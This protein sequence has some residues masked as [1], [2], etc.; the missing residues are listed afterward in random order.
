[1]GWLKLQDHG[2][3]IKLGL[4]EDNLH[5]IEPGFYLSRSGARGVIYHGEAGW[6]PVVGG[7]RLPG[8]YR[9]GAWRTSA[10]GEDV[11]LGV[12]GL[13]RSNLSVPALRR[14]APYGFYV[15]GQQHLTGSATEDAIT[16]RIT[17]RSGLDAFFNYVRTDPRTTRIIDQINV[18]LYFNGPLAS[19]PNDY[20]GIGAARTR[21]NP[22]AAAAEAAS[23]VRSSRRGAEIEIEAHY[24]MHA[25]QGLTLKPS[26]QYIVSPGGRRTAA[27]AVVL[28]FRV[29]ADF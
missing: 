1:M 26:I 25:A 16:G 4:Q 2:F 20:V 14:A 9:A 11:L 22:R 24:G 7:G 21:Y 10:D 28:G 27:D 18:G 6:T 15:Q 23:T 13:P 3:H 12:D 5:N 8:R 19:R 17:R 29:E